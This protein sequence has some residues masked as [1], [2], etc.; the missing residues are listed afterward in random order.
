MTIQ[1]TL[2]ANFFNKQTS[3]RMLQEQIA[4][5]KKLKPNQEW[6]IYKCY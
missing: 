4:H 6:K 3:S 1:L 2:T 5:R